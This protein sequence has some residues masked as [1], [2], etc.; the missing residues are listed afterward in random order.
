MVQ[1]LCGYPFGIDVDSMGSSRGL[2]IGWKTNVSISLRLFSLN[3]ID[4]S[5]DKDSD[6]IKWR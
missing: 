2:F 1:H 3:H 4:I 5:I 6:G